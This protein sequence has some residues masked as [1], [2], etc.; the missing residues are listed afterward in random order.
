MEDFLTRP[1]SYVAG[2]DDV[3]NSRVLATESCDHW[4]KLVFGDSQTFNNPVEDLRA[5]DETGRH[6]IHSAFV[7]SLQPV[8]KKGMFQATHRGC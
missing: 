1:R 4:R 7:K 6:T 5:I 2:A 3:A 8:R